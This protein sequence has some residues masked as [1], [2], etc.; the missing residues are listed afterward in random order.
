MQ[1]STKSHWYTKRSQQG[2]VY[3]HRTMYQSVPTCNDDAQALLG[4]HR[5]VLQHDIRLRVGPYGSGGRM[6]AI[7]KPSPGFRSS[8]DELRKGFVQGLEVP[9]SIPSTATRYKAP[10]T[11]ISSLSPPA[12]ETTQQNVSIS[13]PTRGVSFPSS[14]RVIYDP[15]AA[16]DAPTTSL[17]KSRGDPPSYGAK[18]AKF[19]VCPTERILRST[20]RSRPSLGTQEASPNSAKPA[21]SRRRR[22]D[23][24][25]VRP[26][27]ICSNHPKAHSPISTAVLPT[28]QDA[29]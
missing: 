11:C 3:M 23:H 18:R 25:Q 24:M 9:Q 14:P 10:A 4:V 17:F 12:P 15:I 2:D 19:S 26:P 22:G 28:S 8:D 5:V 21:L 7:R 1:V 13:S 29:P 27:P 20:F 16:S 6:S